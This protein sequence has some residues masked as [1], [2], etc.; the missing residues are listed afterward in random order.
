[1]KALNIVLLATTMLGAGETVNAASCKFQDDSVDKFTKVHSMWT[2]WEPLSSVMGSMFGKSSKGPHEVY[3]AYVS[4]RF[5]G[6]NDY[7]IINI[8]V[9]DYIEMRPPPYE[10]EN[11]IVVPE[12][13]QLL[14][15]MADGAI[16]HL[17]VASAHNFDAN[18]LAPNYGSNSSKNDY[19]K[20][21]DA[22]ISYKLDEQTITALSAQDATNMRIEAGDTYYDIDI[23]KKSTG[24]MA[25]TLECLRQARAGEG[26]AE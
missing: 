24:D 23:H 3:E 16:L 11:A 12:D 25:A 2:R 4:A 8:G 1:M 21:V 17:P 15:L 14:V 22:N 13:S 9:E 18:F 10:L 20:F 26:A 6:D 7:L 5:E 19:W